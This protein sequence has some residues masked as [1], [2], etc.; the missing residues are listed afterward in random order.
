MERQGEEKSH[1]I[2][3]DILFTQKTTVNR[4]IEK[5]KTMRLLRNLIL[6]EPEDV[7][8]LNYGLIMADLGTTTIAPV[9]GIVTHKADK[10]RDV[11]VGDRVVFPRGSGLKYD[12]DDRELLMMRETDI[13]AII[14]KDSVYL[15]KH[16]V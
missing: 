7:T 11:K 14:P 10:A 4:K 12:I 15:Q 3:Y 5:I 16:K 13:M 2:R 6:V 8:K 1:P 9:I